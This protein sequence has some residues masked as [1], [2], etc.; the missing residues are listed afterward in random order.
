MSEKL[1][2]NGLVLIDG[3]FIKTNLVI[4]NGKITAFKTYCNEIGYEQIIDAQDNFVIPGM[5]D[6]H[7]HGGCG[8]DINHAS[9]EDL[10]KV[11]R[12]FASRGVTSYLP[13]I[14]TDTEETMC[15]LLSTIA[16]AKEEQQ[17]GA[18]ILG[19]H[20]EGPFLCVQFKGAMPEDL[21]REGNVEDIKLYQKASKNNIKYMTV[22]PENRG[23]L[24][25]IKYLKQQGIIA[26]FG[27]TGAPYECCVSCIEAGA[28]S[29]THVFN[30]MGSI[31]QHRP[32][33]IGAALESN[34]YCEII[35][36]GFHLHPAI[37]RLI[38]KTKGDEKII[39]IT[40]SI[41]A[42]GLKDG[43]YK[44]GVNDI[45][46]T[47]GDAKLA[48]DGVRAGSTL[49]LDKSLRNLI[50]FTNRPLEKVLPFMTINP[51]KLLKIDNKKGSI[52]IGKDADIVILNKQYM[53]THTLIK[54]K[55]AYERMGHNDI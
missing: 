11:S 5:I 30:A 4:Q 24:D 13:T 45:L 22:S 49:T 23:A 1:I 27:H 39:A 8:I 6:I 25:V 36:D 16:E 50:K 38:I 21:I 40:D 32:D 41:M 52:D 33:A 53:P 19:I 46:V 31:H 37:V 2:K 29:S 18:E 7:T 44:L 15:K 14:L 20:M 10:F 43:K 55:T 12:F 3:T 26:S 9:K 28:S 47:D 42:A 17:D 35:C 51:A 34:V 54:G 48:S